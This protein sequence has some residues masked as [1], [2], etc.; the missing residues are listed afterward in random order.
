MSQAIHERLEPSS[1]LDFQFKFVATII[2]IPPPMGHK[3]SVK[4][5]A[6]NRRKLC[7]SNLGIA[8]VGYH[9]VGVAAKTVMPTVAAESLRGGEATRRAVIAHPLRHGEWRFKVLDCGKGPG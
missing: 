5:V 7:Q 3:R 2:G 9:A 1:K 6:P 4:P 8:D